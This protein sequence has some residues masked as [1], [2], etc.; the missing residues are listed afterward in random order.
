[1]SAPQTAI[2]TVASRRAS[3]ASAIP[4]AASTRPRTAPGDGGGNCTRPDG[5]SQ[6]GTVR[7]A[8]VPAGTGISPVCGW[9]ATSQRAG[10]HV[11]HESADW[12]GPAA[13]A[14]VV[15]GTCRQ[16]RW[17]CPSA[18]TPACASASAAATASGLSTRKATTAIGSSQAAALSAGRRSGLPSAASR[19]RSLVHFV[20]GGVIT[21]TS[22]APRRCGAFHQPLPPMRPAAM[23]VAKH[24]GQSRA[25]SV[26]T[27]PGGGIL[28]Q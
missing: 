24:C 9:P 5:S 10:T 20:V 26:F 3:E 21:V 6:T 15:A 4:A 23:Q 8:Q 7:P 19:R 12:A 22:G 14:S 27:Q 28:R 2:T 1:V 13:G 16:D 11:V 25:E 18:E 17:A